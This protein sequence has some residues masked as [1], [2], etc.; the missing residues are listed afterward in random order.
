MHKWQIKFVLKSGYHMYG[1]YRGT[2]STADA[3]L[4]KIWNAEENHVHVYNGASD[5]GRLFVRHREV[6]AALVTEL[7]GK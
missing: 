4:E 3:V 7:T 5:N 1:V 2:E 6:A